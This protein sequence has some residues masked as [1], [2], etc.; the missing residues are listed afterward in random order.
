MDLKALM[1]PDYPVDLA[2]LD[3]PALFDTLKV[4]R[5]C[6]NSTR[7][8]FSGICTKT[9]QFLLEMPREGSA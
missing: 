4:T 5:F 8:G 3:D 1:S 9:A 6:S 7:N 2:P